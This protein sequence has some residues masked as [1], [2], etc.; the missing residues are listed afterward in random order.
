MDSLPSK[1]WEYGAERRLQVGDERC[2]VSKRERERERE[3]RTWKRN[4]RSKEK[5]LPRMGRRRRVAA[6]KRTRKEDVEEDG[7]SERRGFG[8]EGG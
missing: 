7:W 5:E 8:S 4:G 3:R 1:E 6:G 2:A